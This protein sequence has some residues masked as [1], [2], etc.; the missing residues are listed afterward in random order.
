MRQ[1][2]LKLKL[3]Q[4]QAAEAAGLSPNYFARIER[5]EINL[6]FEKVVRIAHALNTTPSAL[7]KAAEKRL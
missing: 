5:G 1:R 4:E 2:R 3:T 6:T 7:L